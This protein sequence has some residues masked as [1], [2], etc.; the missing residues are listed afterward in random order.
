MG[1][2][3]CK[4][5]HSLMPPMDCPGI[6]HSFGGCGFRAD[7]ALRV[8]SSPDLSAWTLVNQDAYP[9]ES[10]TYG[11]YFRPKVIYNKKTGLYLLWI[12]FLHDAKTPLQS[13]PNAGYTVATSPTPNGPFT[14]V[15]ERANLRYPGS[16]DA[17]IMQ[18]E[19][20]QDA[21]IAYNGWQND[22]R[23]L[24]DKLN[25][26]FTDSLGMEASTGDITDSKQ[27]APILFQRKGWYYLI[28]GHTCC[29]C[30]EGA[31]ASVMA[32]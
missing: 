23:L 10:R 12:N 8:Y 21:Y 1:Y 29:F 17:S 25:D 5:E 2:Q 11:I 22:H 20:G 18:D 4:L 30:T 15:T 13:Y 28:H 7:H 19:N 3:D 27:E 31:G 9:P 26:D 6:Y 16:G 24:I 32:A 14:T